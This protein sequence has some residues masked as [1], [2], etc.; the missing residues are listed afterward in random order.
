M[1]LL[2]VF[3]GTKK[4][5]FNYLNIFVFK[6]I[7]ELLVKSRKKIMKQKKQWKI[8]NIGIKYSTIFCRRFMPAICTV[9]LFLLLIKNSKHI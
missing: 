7:L 6:I 4:F 8:N 3:I 2:L 5:L 1:R 9:L